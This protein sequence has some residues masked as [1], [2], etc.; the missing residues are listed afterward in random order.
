[1]LSNVN[2]TT[3]NVTIGNRPCVVITA[4]PVSMTCIT[5]PSADTTTTT[6]AL[7]AGLAVA[8]PVWVNGKVML[9]SVLIHSSSLPFRLTLFYAFSIPG[10]ACLLFLRS[11]RH[12]GAGLALPHLC[13][14]LRH[15]LRVPHASQYAGHPFV[16]VCYDSYPTA[17]LLISYSPSHCSLY[18]LFD[19]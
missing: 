17:S 8:D 5:P 9:I 11:R 13:S 14:H 1:M 16:P 6:A 10:A 18:N 2:V 15:H 3:N 4:S 12:P 7:A 19:L